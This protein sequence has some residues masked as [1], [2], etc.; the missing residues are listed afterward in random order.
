MQK[1]SRHLL[2]T[3]LSQR[4]TA[5]QQGEGL[6]KHLQDTKPSHS[7]S[8]KELLTVLNALFD[9]REEEKSKIHESVLSHIKSLILPCIDALRRTG[10]SKKQDLLVNLMEARLNH[11]ASSYCLPFTT[12]HPAFTP[13][14][15][16]VAL[17]VRDGK[18]TKEIASFMGVSSRAIDFH[19][20]NMR[21]KLGLVKSKQTLRA[22]LLSLT[23]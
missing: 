22:R 15:I 5:L 19:R 4:L 21:K 18:T 8:I 11:V 12:I 6:S 17:L 10:L 14:E 20:Y 16:Q 1:P 13:K 9:F 2:E 23:Y 7:L 3:E